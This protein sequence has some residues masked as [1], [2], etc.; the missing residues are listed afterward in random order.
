MTLSIAL[1]TCIPA[2][3]ADRAVNAKC[4]SALRTGPSFGLKSEEP[5]NPLLLYHG[6]IPEETRAIPGSVSFIKVL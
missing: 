1:L 2:L 3:K 4:A 5:V 6:K